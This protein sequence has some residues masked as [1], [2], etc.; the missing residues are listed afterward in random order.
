MD[1]TFFKLLAS[2]SIN[3]NH[4][5]K[6]QKFS[7][8]LFLKY[9]PNWNGLYHFTG[10]LNVDRGNLRNWTPKNEFIYEYTMEEYF[11][12]C[13]YFVWLS[14]LLSKFWGKIL[15]AI[16]LLY[17]LMITYGRK[18]IFCIFFEISW[19]VCA[20]LKFGCDE[21]SEIRMHLFRY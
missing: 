3:W 21:N 4:Q 16:L 5:L 20:N 6:P 19:D 18:E 8:K 14:L 7:Q 11:L 10:N 9:F 12:V 15:Q 13:F 17:Q 2:D 1:I